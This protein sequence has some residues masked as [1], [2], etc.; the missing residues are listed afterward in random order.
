MDIAASIQDVTEKIILKLVK[1]L[2]NEYKIENLCLAG[3]VALNCVANGKIRKEKIFENIWI[4][5]AAGD[6]GTA[7]GAALYYWYNELN[8]EKKFTAKDSMRGSFLGPSFTSSKIETQLTTLVENLKHDEETII[9]N[10]AKEIAEGKA[11][12]GLMKKWNL[13]RSL[14][15]RSIIA[16]PRNDIMQR[17]LNLK[18]KFRESFGPFAPSVL[19]EDLNDWF[20]LKLRVHICF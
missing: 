19:Y 14:G 17:Q 13:T 3:G 18:I 5:P 12:D 20:D 11:M 7:I 10:I 16:D 4:Q 2:R 1:N 9:S 8:N 15:S 6:S